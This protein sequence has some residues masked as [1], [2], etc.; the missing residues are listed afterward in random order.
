[1]STRPLVLT[2]ALV[3]LALAWSSRAEAEIPQPWGII[4]GFSVEGGIGGNGITNDRFAIRVFE[5]VSLEGGEIR[6]LIGFYGAGFY[7]IMRYVSVGLSFQYA[8]LISEYAALEHGTGGALGI[9]AEVRGHFPVSRFDPWVGLG[10]GYAMAFGAGSG[11]VDNPFITGEYDGRMAFHGVGIG[12]STG[13]NVYLTRQWTLGLYVRL[14]FGGYTKACYDFT[15]EGSSGNDGGDY[16][17]SIEV[18]YDT[19]HVDVQ[20]PEDLPHLW[21][22]GLNVTYFFDWPQSEDEDEDEEED[23]GGDA[24]IVDDETFDNAGDAGGSGGADEGEVDDA[25]EEGSD[26]DAESAEDEAEAEEE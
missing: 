14:I 20:Q 19:D 18:V 5:D 15:Y 22:V 6:P 12:L 4:H 3:V 7:R 11:H 13:A 17:N 26:D 9:L 10:L 8:F 2:P 24:V 1:M 16:C 25:G 23:D 21:S